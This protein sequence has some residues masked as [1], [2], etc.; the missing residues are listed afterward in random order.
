MK[1]SNKNWRFN[2]DDD[3]YVA[4]E[5]EDNLVKWTI[6]IIE[7]PEAHFK[8][9]DNR[10]FGVYTEQYQSFLSFLTN[11]WR[12]DIPKEIHSE[13]AG[14][15]RSNYTVEDLEDSY[16]KMANLRFHYWTP[17]PEKMI[18]ERGS[19]ESSEE[20]YDVDKGILVIKVDFIDPFDRTRTQELIEYDTILA[21][22]KRYPNEVLEYVKNL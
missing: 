16:K 12:S 1:K 17:L 4:I 8:A 18:F 3:K 21:N 13:I 9:E 14:I 11:P 22:P 10:R 15:I 20:Y 5:I 2:I 7:N 6:D 19:K